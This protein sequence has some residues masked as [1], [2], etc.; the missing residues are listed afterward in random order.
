[1]NEGM[2]QVKE[3]GGRAELNKFHSHSH[4]DLDEYV[5]FARCGNERLSCS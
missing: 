4:R 5:E 1:M 3:V 2:R